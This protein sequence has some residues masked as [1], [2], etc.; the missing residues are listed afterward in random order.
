MRLVRNPSYKHS[1]ELINKF[2][3]YKNLISFKDHSQYTEELLLA[4][5]DAVEKSKKLSLKSEHILWITDQVYKHKLSIKQVEE[6]YLPSLKLHFQ[7]K[8]LLNPIGQYK[9]VSE[10][11]TD[12]QKLEDGENEFVSD[13]EM[14]VFFEKD[15]WRLALPHTTK[16]SCLLGK[17][18]DWC[19]ART[20]SENL[21][22]QYVGDAKSDIFIFYIIRVNANSRKNPDDKMSIGF[23]N[24]KPI[25]DGK[26]GG[27]TVNSKNTGITLDKYKKLLGEDLAN[28]FLLQ[29][30]NKIIKFGGKHPLKK[31]LTLVAKSPKKY[32]KKANEY[33]KNKELDRFKRILNEYELDKEVDLLLNNVGLMTLDEFFLYINPSRAMESDTYFEEDYFDETYNR[34]KA[35][36]TAVNN[37]NRNNWEASIFSDNGVVIK[38]DDEE[39]ALCF[40][41]VLYYDG[42]FN[43]EYIPMYFYSGSYNLHKEYRIEYKKTK[44]VKYIRKEIEK[45]RD[46]SKSNKLKYSNVIEKIKTPV[47]DLSIVSQKEIEKNKNQDMF[48]M[49]EEGKIVGYAYSSAGSNILLPWIYRDFD[50]DGVF[51]YFLGKAN[52]SYKY[53]HMSYSDIEAETKRWSMEVKE[54]SENGTYQR[55]IKEGI[56]TEDKVMEIM[57]RLLPQHKQLY[58]PKEKKEGNVIIHAD[59]SSFCIYNTNFFES[60]SESDI[61]AYGFFRE[62]KRVG[63]FFLKIDYEDNFGEIIVLAALQSLRNTG[64]RLYIGQGYK[65]Y[66]DEEII[67]NINRD[68]GSPITRDGDYIFLNTDVL[69]LNRFSLFE[70]NY[71]HQ[72]FKERHE[73]IEKI[74]NLLEVAEAKW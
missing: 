64:E 55:L 20:K 18:T 22:L 35:V 10:L 30:T 7:N 5:L 40:D 70:K 28:E 67:D 21:F 60:N 31:E 24:G 14:D 2:N 65:D 6:D 1:S 71:I 19:T 41:D 38:H 56:I 59:D 16:A 29:M 58:V 74:T 51:A 34:K 26:D 17:E 45:Y 48:V 23:F 50:I 13:K 32:L 11:N 36:H 37:L 66:F 8:N 47:G 33:K 52:P 39:V 53:Q 25:F 15:N 49:T 63:L 12:I 42:N 57:S 27:M 3:Y 61:L 44:A 62:N 69:D 73:R 43:P 54:L 68:Y 9:N 4:T 72:N 46:I